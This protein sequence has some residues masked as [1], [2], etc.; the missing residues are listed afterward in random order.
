MWVNFWAKYINFRTF[1]SKKS[2]FS[3]QIIEFLNYLLEFFGK[4]VWICFQLEFFGPWVF[5]KCPKT[6]WLVSNINKNYPWF[7]AVLVPLFG[8]HNLTSAFMPD[9]K[10]WPGVRKSL[11]MFSALSISF[12]GS[13]VAVIF[14]FMNS[15][16]GSQIEKALAGSEVRNQ[17]TC[18][19][20]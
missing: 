4:F 2:V 7:S 17:K 16:V 18:Q 20:F 13:I 19:A 14:C 12:Q 8:L 6:A 11:E 15:E 10:D 9:S 1:L 3:W 5:S